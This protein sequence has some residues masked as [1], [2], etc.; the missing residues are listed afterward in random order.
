MGWE[1][2][3]YMITIWK[4]IFS[5]W[6]VAYMRLQVM[7]LGCAARLRPRLLPGGYGW[8]SNVVKPLIINIPPWLLDDVKRPPAMV[9]YIYIYMVYGIYMAFTTVPSNLGFMKP[10]SPG[11]LCMLI[12]LHYLK[13][14]PVNTWVLWSHLVFRIWVLGGAGAT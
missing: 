6:H 5:G 10:P 3:A 14:Q 1:R 12:L 2:I 7:W 9:D 13:R 11:K 4:N 8:K